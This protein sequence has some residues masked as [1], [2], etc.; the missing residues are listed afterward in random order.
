VIALD[1]EG[2]RQRLTLL[3]KFADGVRG[4]SLANVLYVS[5]Q[6]RYGGGGRPHD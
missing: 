5:L 1:L 2:T 6:G 3:E 4:T